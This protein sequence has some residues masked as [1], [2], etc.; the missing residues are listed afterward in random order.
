MGKLTGMN[1]GKNYWNKGEV[2]SQRT[3]VLERLPSRRNLNN[4]EKRSPAGG[5]EQA[6]RKVAIGGETEA[7]KIGRS[8][9]AEIEDELLEQGFGIEA[10]IHDL[11]VR[12]DAMKGNKIIEIKPNTPSGIKAGKARKA[13]LEKH[14]YEVEIRYYDPAEYAEKVYE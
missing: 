13:F 6:V 10:P 14:G 4:P 3:L 12:V 7:T 1:R 5:A 2:R 11:G 9:H 8:A